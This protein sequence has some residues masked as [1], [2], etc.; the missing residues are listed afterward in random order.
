MIGTYIFYLFSFHDHFRI[1]KLIVTSD[2]FNLLTNPFPPS[3]KID[4][5]PD[6]LKK[7]YRT[8]WEISQKS[9]INMSADRGAY[10]DQSQSLNIH[11]AEPTY[12]KLSSMHFYA[13]KKGL[14]TGLYY[15]R[16][17]PAADPIKFTV[18][19]TK[20][21][22]PNTAKPFDNKENQKQVLKTNAPLTNGTPLTE[23]KAEKKTLVETTAV[24][25]KQLAEPV[26]AEVNEKDLTNNDDLLEQLK[27]ACS[28]AN[29][30]ACTMC[31]S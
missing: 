11:L 29:K 22:Q 10:I 2:F 4:E 14:K 30:E 9:L 12:G 18:D 28:L 5:I 20:L 31:S 7:L 26:A 15:L 6:D 25:N 19:K 13:W 23:I 3:Q 21:K 16:T 8:V 24:I 1:S 17:R 27:M